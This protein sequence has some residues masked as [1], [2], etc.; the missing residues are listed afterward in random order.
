MSR[1]LKALQQ[2]EARRTTSSASAGRPGA[3][4]ESGKSSAA[5]AS[6]DEQIPAAGEASDGGGDETAEAADTAGDD[7]AEQ[8]QASGD[9]SKTLVLGV[10][11]R[12]QEPESIT[13]KRRVPE[14]STLVLPNGPDG[15][16]GDGG[17][18]PELTSRRPAA[19]KDAAAEMNSPAEGGPAASKVAEAEGPKEGGQG[20]ETRPG[21]ARDVEEAEEKSGGPEVIAKNVTQKYAPPSE[22]EATPKW[23]GPELKTDAGERLADVARFVNELLE[24]SKTA[25]REEVQ[26]AIKAEA[27]V[28][29]EPAEEATSATSDGQPDIPPSE[30]PA[31]R[32]P[33]S[34]GAAD[35]QNPPR[36]A[37]A[38]QTLVTGAANLVNQLASQPDGKQVDEVAVTPPVAEAKD[39]D[40]ENEPREVGRDVDARVEELKRSESPAAVETPRNEEPPASKS[41]AEQYVTFTE[42]EE[43]EQNSGGSQEAAQQAV[44][45]Q[46]QAASHGG[47]DSDAAASD[48]ESG[49]SEEAAIAADD[50]SATTEEGTPPADSSADAQESAD[51]ISAPAAAKAP[52]DGLL[53][54]R[55]QQP[56]R[57]LAS[58]TSLEEEVRQR[59]EDP[60]LGKSYRRMAE[61]CKSQYP[62]DVA[63]ALMLAG[64]TASLQL[65]ETAFSLAT[66]LVDEQGDDDQQFRVLVVDGALS[67]KTLTG[68]LRAASNPGLAE[69]LGRRKSWR[70]Y[71]CNTAQANV[72][73]LPAGE[74]TVTSYKSI[75]GLLAPLIGEWKQ[76][77]RYIIFDAGGADEPLAERLAPA[78]DATYLLVTAGSTEAD[79]A[80]A[81]AERLQTAGARLRGCILVDEPAPRT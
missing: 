13:P 21:D 51:E 18:E 35:G 17:P 9:V 72:D 59:L 27:A 11:M 78:C 43:T 12:P 38:G 26:A 39:A 20:E 36:D 3:A 30:A 74:G 46:E 55:F 49:E 67:E 57:P 31:L 69:V 60:L 22:E 8:Q 28:S 6:P 61:N 4:S 62:G 25:N 58:A 5:D 76:Q 33:W 7:V 37:H 54:N 1:M 41:D 65:G 75:R 23:S 42:P 47:Q 64:P 77:Y 40:A 81:A 70:D 66:G 80:R 15:I 53:K 68:R 24:A 73:F 44:P 16:F 79:D 34:K 14:S 29:S 45:A 50:S 71:V 63:A 56:T 32:N 48:E 2:L 52:G 10:N 19:E